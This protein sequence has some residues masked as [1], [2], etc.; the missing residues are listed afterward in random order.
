MHE[1]GRLV[2]SITS[3]RVSPLREHTGYVVIDVGQMNH[4]A[5]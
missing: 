4:E 1:F 5:A 2:E 3:K